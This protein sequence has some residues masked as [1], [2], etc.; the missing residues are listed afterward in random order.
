MTPQPNDSDPLIPAFAP[1]PVRPR[2][3]GWTAERQRTFVAVLAE[4]G[5]VTVAAR[6]A[7]MSERSAHRLALREDAGDFCD[8][9]DAALRIAARRAV[10]RLYE[11]GLDGMTETVWRD[12]EIVYRRR[13]PSEKALFFLLSRIDP[14]HFGRPGAADHPCGGD[15]AAIDTVGE[16]ASMFDLTLA[17]LHDL[18]PGDECDG[19]IDSAG[20]RDEADRAADADDDHD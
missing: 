4:T 9:W 11:Y 2:R 10:S 18:P 15:G 17:A 5:L 6:A 19:D 8:A 16:A 7:G 13:R 3:D 12:G 14:A 1:V 20:D